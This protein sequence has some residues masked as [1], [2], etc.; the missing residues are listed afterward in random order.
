MK[1]LMTK[2]VSEILS[3]PEGTLRYWRKVGLGPAWI[4][5]EGTIRYAEEDVLAY[6]KCNRRTPSV[7][8]YME[9]KECYIGEEQPGTMTSRSQDAAN[10]GRPAKPRSLEPERLNRN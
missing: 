5:L 4:K 10:V 8:A 6:I 2:A 7:R 3:V 1:L 9:E